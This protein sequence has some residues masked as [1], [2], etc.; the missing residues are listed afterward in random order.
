[1]AKARFNKFRQ[2]IVE[3]SVYNQTSESRLSFIKKVYGYFTISLLYSLFGAILSMKSLGFVLKSGILFP[4]IMIV[5]LYALFINRKR[6]PLNKI[7]LFAF[8][9]IS[10]MSIGPMLFTFEITGNMGIVVQALSL[11]VIAFGGLTA[12][13]WTTKKDFSYLRGF[14]ITGIILL[15]GGI[16]LNFFIMSSTFNLV[17]SMFGVMLFSIFILYDTQNIMKRYSEDEYIMGAVDLYLDFL[18]LFLYILSIL[19][20]DD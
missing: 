7:L 2:E 12:Y 13:A 16:L 15:I 1:M 11:T 4:I 3:T 8:T 18:N 6:E 20:N 10:G 19:S 5:T 9:F 14:L 17:I